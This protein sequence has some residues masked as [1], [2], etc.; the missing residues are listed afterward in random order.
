[1]TALETLWVQD[2]IMETQQY[3]VAERALNLELGDVSDH[4]AFW[5]WVWL[6]EKS[7]VSTGNYKYHCKWE[8]SVS[9]RLAITSPAFILLFLNFRGRQTTQV[10]IL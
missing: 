3:G 10:I 4:P 7:T 1:M 9:E 8:K 2:I 6:G 5:L